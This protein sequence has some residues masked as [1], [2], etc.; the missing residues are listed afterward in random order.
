ME[1]F[2]FPH[3]LDFRGRAYPIHG[4]LNHHGFDL[5]RCL[6]EFSDGKLGLRWLKIHLDNLYGSG[7]DKLPYDGRVEFTDTH[8]EDIYDSAD[9]PIEGKRWWLDA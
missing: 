5:C 1:G 4:H 3:N 2:Y 6:L 7:V 8:L 9:N